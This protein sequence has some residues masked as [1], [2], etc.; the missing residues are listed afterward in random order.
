[1]S[2][3]LLIEGWRGINHSYAMVNQYQMLALAKL[4]IDF[5]HHDLPFF[6]PNWNQDQNFCG[7]D[8]AAISRL[9]EIK[10][11]TDQ[12][13]IDA[14]YRIS[15]PYRLYPSKSDHLF[16]FGTSEY[17]SVTDDMIFDD[18]LKIK[19]ADRP[20]TI[21]T[22]SNW[23]KVGF[24]KAGF[25]DEQ[26]KV[27]PHGVDQSIFKPLE[28]DVRDQYRNALGSNKDTFVILSVGAM[29]ANKGIDLL[30]GAYL[31]LKPKYPQIKLVLKDQ[32]NLYGISANDVINQ[33][34]T[35]NGINLSSNEMRDAVQGFFVISQNLNLNQ[36]NGLYNAAD[37]YV[38]PYR[39][40]GFNLTPLEAAAAGTPII[41]TKGGSTD[42]YV[43]ESFATQIASKMRLENGM[44]F[45][46]PSLE[47]LVEKIANQIN[48]KSIDINIK[49][50]QTFINQTFTWESIAKKFILEFS[51]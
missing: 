38:S 36:L 49:A 31:Q 34:C 23:S 45:L 41:V 26:V 44:S 18:G 29:T 9:N 25:R 43:D 48:R 8:E 51:I 37:C 7:F 6:N 11:Y 15:F 27:I 50:R 2:K 47:S 17:Q 5:C 42:D 46:E 24:L 10:T 19:N 40:E 32:S 14:T 21:I 1:M 33:Y 22:P 39:A 13:Q 28:N 3:R 30:L 16:V 4:G 20:L 35:S 12:D